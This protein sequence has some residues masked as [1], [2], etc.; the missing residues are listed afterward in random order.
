MGGGLCYCATLLLL[1]RP[2]CYRARAVLNPSP[3]VTTIIGSLAAIGT[4]AAWLP[5]VFKTLR[6]GRADDFSRGYLAL[7]AS[8]VA[9]WL[10]YGILRHDPVIIVANLATLALVL[11]I[12][13]VKVRSRRATQRHSDAATK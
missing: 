9:L 13:V 12:V 11:V 6:T 10:V 2:I 8:G 5:Q 1:L 3:T 4:T 7:F